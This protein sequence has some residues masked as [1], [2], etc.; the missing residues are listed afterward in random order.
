[1]Q[2]DSSATI[3]L[4]DELELVRGYLA[5]E[6]LQLED[7]LAYEFDIDQ[8][9][10]AAAVPPLLLQTLVENAIRHGVARRQ[11]GGT[12]RIGA[13][14]VGDHRWRLEIENPPAELNA[15]QPSSG[16]GLR[17]ARERLDAAFDGQA[18]LELATGA[19]VRATAELPL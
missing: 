4:Q 6:A 9:L 10:M 1:M 15:S 7:R 11:Q 3:R 2:S 5:L 18:T 12:I 8:D 17:N 19:I 16:I 13:A 14:P